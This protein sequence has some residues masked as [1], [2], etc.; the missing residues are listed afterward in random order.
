MRC[1][2]EIGELR[3]VLPDTTDSAVTTWDHAALKCWY[4]QYA[5]L[6]VH[7]ARLVWM[8]AANRVEGYHPTVACQAVMANLP[9]DLACQLNMAECR[10][11]AWCSEPAQI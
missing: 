3:Q 1:T 10:P 9:Y 7:S 5:T 8:A 4:Y 2:S 6:Q 11:K